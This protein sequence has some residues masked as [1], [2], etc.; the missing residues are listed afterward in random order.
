MFDRL[1][2]IVQNALD[3]IRDDKIEICDEDVE[4]YM[5]LQRWETLGLGFNDGPKTHVR[6]YT[7]VVW[8]KNHTGKAIVYFGGRFAYTVDKPN[9]TFQKCLSSFSMPKVA[10]KGMLG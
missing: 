6:S 10:N 2:R 9:D 5:F 4:V 1:N 7:V 3:R 8:D